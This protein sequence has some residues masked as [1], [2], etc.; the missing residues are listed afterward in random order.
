MQLKHDR[1]AQANE[2]D[3]NGN[4][5]S[6]PPGGKHGAKPYVSVIPGRVRFMISTTDPSFWLL[7]SQ[8]LPTR[9]GNSFS[10][11]G[12]TIRSLAPYPSATRIPLPCQGFP[13]LRVKQDPHPLFVEGPGANGLADF[14][15]PVRQAE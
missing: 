4:Q 8:D 10:R 13:G 5:N 12:P 11:S 14:P 9:P 1:D 6:S 3:D 2:N 7:I 15:I